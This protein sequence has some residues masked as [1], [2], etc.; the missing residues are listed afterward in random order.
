[1][2]ISIVEVVARSLTPFAELYGRSELQRVEESAGKLRERLGGGV[3]WNINS[4]ARGGGVAELLQS[5]VAYSRGASV[6]TRWLVMSG[7]PE[8]FRLTKQLHNAIHGHA[9]E[10]FTL[11]QAERSVYESTAREVALEL[12]AIVRPG[13]VVILHDPQPA[14][15]CEALSRHGA[16]VIW[17]CHIGRDEANAE[18]LRA[19]DFLAPYVRHAAVRVFTRQAYI[20]PQLT[21]ARN[22]IIPPTIDPASAKNQAMS[23]DTAHAILVH[24]GIVEGPVPQG[25]RCE[26]MLSDG[27]LS[28][29]RRAADVIRLGRAPLWNVPLIVQVSRWDRLKDPIGVMQGFAML[30]SAGV[31]ASLVLAGPN[32]RAVADDPEGAEVFMEVEAAWRQLP[33]GARMNA[34]E[35]AA[36]VNALQRHASVVV[37]KSLEEGF[38]LTVA[39]AMWKARPVV[40]SRVGGI[41]DQI[42]H[43]VS[44]LLLDNPSD[45]RQ[46]TA[47]LRRVLEAPDL[48]RRLGVQAN[49]RVRDL[50]VNL[51]SLYAYTDLILTITDA[52]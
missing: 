39:E 30:N 12:I 16:H 9:S 45:P 38:G 41:Q 46:L 5:V 52:R 8:F 36:M 28:T 18:S 43:E 35:N 26:F 47:A 19:W 25:A 44:G 17:R 2:G 23:D 24:A 42:E 37:Q 15:L 32:V 50:F 3:I 4:T 6:D 21:D 13:D 22:V 10:G 29:V 1:M 48:A 40:A 33:H 34:Q 31:D 7:S 14:G 51:R 27:S 49:K 11:G 20:P